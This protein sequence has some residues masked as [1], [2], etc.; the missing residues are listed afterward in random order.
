MDAGDSLN[1]N[2]SLVT[3]NL[4]S[5]NYYIYLF[6]DAKDTVYEGIKEKQ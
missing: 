3:P 5:G 1:V 4:S 6:S 2:T